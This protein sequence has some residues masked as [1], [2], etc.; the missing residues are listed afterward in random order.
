V[1]T[2]P[3]LSSVY[4]LSEPSVVL[5][6]RSPGSGVVPLSPVTGGVGDC[7]PSSV[8]GAVGSVLIG[9]VV[10][11]GSN[12]GVTSSHGPVTVGEGSGWL[13]VGLGVNVTLSVPK[14]TVDE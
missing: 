14:S 6:A 2:G 5:T 9:S 4:G 11:S 12:G 1:D 7:S 3:V 13:T 10:V 8:A